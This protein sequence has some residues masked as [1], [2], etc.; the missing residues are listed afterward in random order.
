M[1]Q[2]LK[3]ALAVVLG[4]VIGSIGYALVGNNQSGQ[5]GAP[6]GVSSITRYPNSGLAARFMYIGTTMP[7]TAQTD[8]SFTSTGAATLS[9]TNTL[10]GATTLSGSTTLSATTTATGFAQVSNPLGSA[11]STLYIGSSSGTGY[12]PGCLVLGSSGGVTSTPVYVT[13][14]G[15]T[16]SATTTK[17]AVCR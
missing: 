4:I 11:S 9:G 5:F 13:A 7:T 1:N 6:I 15:T 10:S 17:P 14:T 8:G 16:I 12:F 3:T 2:T